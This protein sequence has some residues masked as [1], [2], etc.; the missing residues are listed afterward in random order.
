MIEIEEVGRLRENYFFFERMVI[1]IC[2]SI[3]FM[4]P[5]LG[6][7]TPWGWPPSLGNST[8]GDGHGRKVSMQHYPSTG[9]R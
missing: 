5:S 7:F 1:E 2:I 6:E 3:H 8:L 9:C 4:P